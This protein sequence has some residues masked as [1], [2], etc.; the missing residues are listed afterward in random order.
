MRIGPARGQHQTA[1]PVFPGID[2]HPDKIWAPSL[3]DRHGSHFLLHP[4]AKSLLQLL[5]HRAAV[6]PADEDPSSSFLLF[7]TGLVS[8]IV[9]R[10]VGDQT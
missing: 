9:E 10:R 2:A 3:P 7:I 1:T 4:G 8:G 5:R 6:S